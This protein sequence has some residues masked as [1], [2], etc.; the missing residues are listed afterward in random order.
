MRK[1]HSWSGIAA[2]KQM[3]SYLHYI[4]LQRTSGNPHH[5]CH[6][7]I[8]TLGMHACK[9]VIAAS[10]ATMYGYSSATILL[11]FCGMQVGTWRRTPTHAHPVVQNTPTGHVETQNP[12]SDRDR[13]PAQHML[14]AH[15][16][17]PVLA[18]D[19]AVMRIWSHL[20]AGQVSARVMAKG[21]VAYLPRCRCSC[22]TGDVSP[23]PYT[24]AWRKLDGIHASGQLEFDSFILEA[25]NHC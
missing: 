18:H 8:R 4:K 17:V 3:S 21:A 1:A 13:G 5:G 22:C 7:S 12:P 25:H 10:R 6:V 15:C 14:V 19:S 2:C 16:P 23:D 24:L 9:R 20:H 11:E